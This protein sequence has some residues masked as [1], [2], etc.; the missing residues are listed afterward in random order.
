MYFIAHL[1]GDRE[2]QKKWHRDLREPIRNLLDNHAAERF[3]LTYHY[4]GHSDNLYLCLDAP[5]INECTLDEILPLKSMR[6]ISK[7]LSEEI[8]EARVKVASYEKEASYS[9]LSNLAKQQFENPSK[10]LVSE[11]AERQID[12]A[13][14][15]SAAALRIL[16]EGPGDIND[17]ASLSEKVFEYCSP[18]N[19]GWFLSDTAHFCFNS[20]GVSPDEEQMAQKMYSVNL[21]LGSMIQRLYHR[22]GWTPDD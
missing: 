3:V 18:L 5:E 20:L 19:G 11:L 6:S 10:K 14:R 13:S 12:N 2:E 4:G 16:A 22:E 17:W 8:G 9:I 21:S 7:Y 15:G 1:N